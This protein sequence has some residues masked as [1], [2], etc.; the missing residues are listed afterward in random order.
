MENRSASDP[1]QISLKLLNG[2]GAWAHPPHT[3]PHTHSD[4]VCPSLSGEQR[5]QRGL[6]SCPKPPD[7]FHVFLVMSRGGGRRVTCH[8]SALRRSPC[9][10]SLPRRS[11]AD[12]LLYMSLPNEPPT[13]QSCLLCTLVIEGLKKVL[14]TCSTFSLLLLARSLTLSLP[15]PLPCSLA[16][17]WS[18]WNQVRPLLSL[19][20]PTPPCSLI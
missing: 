20:H 19:T 10:G 15:R 5:P 11:A 18:E 8:V 4:C 12:H 2:F 3:H 6:H 14:I 17:W 1:S 7:L 16:C 9:A 13:P